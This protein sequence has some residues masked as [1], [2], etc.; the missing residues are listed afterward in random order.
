M[1]AFKFRSSSQIDF[2]FDIIFNQ[3]LHC[4]DWSRLNDP[5]E[6]IFSYS[7]SSTGGEDPKQ[8]VAKIIRE[9][10]RIKVCSLSRTFDCHLLWAHYA[11][12]FSGVAVEVELPDDPKKVKIVNYRGVFAELNLNRNPNPY[13]TARQILS[14]KYREWEYEQEVRILHRDEW[15][16]LQRP[17]CR[18]IAGHRM[19]PALFEALRIVCDSKKIPFRKTGIGDTGIDADYIEAIA[20]RGVK[21]LPRKRSARGARNMIA[22]KD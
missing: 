3:R 5:M 16:P 21:R 15:F 17:V 19:T 4:A 8:R 22:S 10:Q 9:K 6:G 2:A 12:G 14:S 18:V 13:S 11:S 1:R 20:A 7:F